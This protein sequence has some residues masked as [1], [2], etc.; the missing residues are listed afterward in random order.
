M[1]VINLRERTLD[2]KI[3]Y[4]GAALSGKTTSLKHVH[5]VMDPDRRTEL[6]SLN[7]EGDRTLFFD[8]LPIPLGSVGGFKVRLQGFT[9]PGQVK[10][11]LTR[12]FV[13]RGADAV[14]FV[15]DSGAE[16][17]EANVLSLRSLHENL[18]VNGLEA[19][20]LPIL[21][22]YNK[23][24]LPDPVE[25]ERLREALN[26][27]GWPEYPT[28]ATTGG[29]VFEAF[30]HVSCDML[31]S[32]AREY[33]FSEGEAAREEVATRLTT[34]QR[35]YDAL[36]ADE[37]EVTAN[38]PSP[39]A[40]DDGAD[41]AR[42]APVI[43]VSGSPDEGEANVE[44]LLERA[45][46]THMEAARLMSEL[47]AT[48]TDLSD[49]VNQLAALHETG[50]LISSELDGKK[51]LERILDRALSTVGSKYGS[52]LLVDPVDGQ[53]TTDLVRGY[54]CDPLALA[55]AAPPELAE[56]VLAGEAFAVRSQLEPGLLKAPF[57]NVD[58]PALAL[59]SPIVHQAEVLGI[60]TAYFPT[61][62][63][64]DWA[65][66]RAQFL[67]AVS[68]QAA[69]A[70]VNSRLYARIEGF[71]R[72]LERKVRE[73]TRALRRAY[74]DLQQLDGL[75]DDFLASMSHELLTPLTS[76][77]GFAEILE[78]TAA[79][80]G[81]DA[82][83]NRH[84]FATI[85]RREAGNLTAL[86]QTV[87]DLCTLES[88]QAPLRTGMVN[89]RDTLEG[90]YREMRG[91]F[92]D[93]AIR[94]RVRVEENMPLVHADAAWLERVFA[95]LLSNALKFSP[96]GGEASVSI[97]RHGTNVLVDVTDEGPGVP[98]ALRKVIFEKFKQAGDL[99]TEKP[100][101]LGLGLPMA[102]LI[103]EGM[104]GRI[105][106]E[107][108]EGGGSAFAFMLPIEAPPEPSGPPAPRREDAID[109][110]DLDDD[111]DEESGDAV[112][113]PSPL[114]YDGAEPAAK[115]PAE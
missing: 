74:R 81:G 52:V 19:T 96:S 84:E 3:V 86:V 67:S 33:G 90:A 15:A 47:H 57:M 98:A 44:E 45:V 53:L 91:A 79:D 40:A 89:V 71:N 42:L 82:A 20:G 93:R 1:S 62:P 6:V 66:N 17:F 68:A 2:A 78:T 114:S 92:K 65:R 115:S 50:V 100:E 10:Y 25:I 16:A 27:A 88:G 61:D 37:F 14:I 76:I 21:I 43:E 7:T 5:R 28:T 22:Q 105:W 9:V 51:L 31:E 104:G 48:R 38:A 103:D 29:G 58:P 39:L 112:T 4:Y 26:D 23:R 63:G 34:V 64:D 102:R 18:A 35:A 101:G 56:R 99:L 54:T 107:T 110:E 77:T 108:P 97:R 80:E 32:L 69:A 94:V 49:R 106:Y 12:R 113:S 8:F 83:E 30:R 73:R 95:S 59:I 36:P 55:G 111:L 75:K 72:E 11:N 60:L 24:D 85:V 70:L 109:L 46:D 87:L 13:L 41:E